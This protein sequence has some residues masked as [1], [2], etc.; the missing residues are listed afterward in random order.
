M[1]YTISY[2][3]LYTTLYTIYYTTSYTTSYTISY[4]MFYALGLF[5][6]SCAVHCDGRQ[7]AGVDG[8]GRTLTLICSSLQGSGQIQNGRC[9]LQTEMVLYSMKTWTQSRNGWRTNFVG[10]IQCCGGCQ[11]NWPSGLARIFPMLCWYLTRRRTSGQHLSWM[12]LSFTTLCVVLMVICV[13]SVASNGSA[14]CSTED[15]RPCVI[16]STSTAIVSEAKLHRYQSSYR[17]WYR[18]RHRIRYHIRYDIRYNIRYNIR[19]GIRYDILYTISYMMS[20]TMSYTI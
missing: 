19:Y 18:I 6:W 15:P 1:S 3:T 17:I 12:T 14:T 9:R 13:R 20:Y 10:P 16:P 7:W 11:Q 5:C 4:T 8:V 2:T